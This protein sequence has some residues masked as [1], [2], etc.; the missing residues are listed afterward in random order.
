MQVPWVSVATLTQEH[1]YEGCRSGY[2][3]D[4]LCTWC[5]PYTVV[6]RTVPWF[7][8]N[9]AD[10]LYRAEHHGVRPTQVHPGSVSSAD[11]LVPSADD[12]HRDTMVLDPTIPGA[13]GL[14]H[15]PLC[16]VMF[17][18]HLAPW[19]VV[20]SATIVVGSTARDVPSQLVLAHRV[21]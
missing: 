8:C 14:D 21:S 4:M 11:G 18:T 20:G 12:M 17:T 13:A 1:V 15:H 16:E 5:W 9:T 2:P 3:S 19:D 10:P 6:L 7:S